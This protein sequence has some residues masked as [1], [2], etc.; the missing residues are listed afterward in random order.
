VV[1]AVPVHVCPTCALH[2]TAYVVE[3]GRVVGTWEVVS[4]DRVLT[5]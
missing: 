5:V 2:R 3:G 1:Y 4:R